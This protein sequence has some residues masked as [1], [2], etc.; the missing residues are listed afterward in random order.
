MRGKAPVIFM[1][2]DLV[3][4]A[5]DLIEPVVASLGMELVD[6]VFVQEHG[7]PILRIYA[8]KEGGITIGDITDISREISTVLDVEDF[9]DKK[10]MLE[11]SSPGLDRPLTKP[12]HFEKVVGKK[13]RVRIKE[14]MDG[15]RNFKGTL[16]SCTDDMLKI[17]DNDG[18]EF[19]IELGNVDKARLEIEF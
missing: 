14:A 8:D 7:S 4:K 2:N 18:V 17:T 12:E 13:I 19:E 11:V 3:C 1:D 5:R 9:I 15:R 6:V 10:Y 16:D